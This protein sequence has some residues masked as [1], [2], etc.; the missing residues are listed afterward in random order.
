MVAASCGDDR[1]EPRHSATALADGVEVAVDDPDRLIDSA[2]VFL[3]DE[4]PSYLSLHP[5][6]DETGIA[7]LQPGEGGFD[8]VVVV[9][10]TGPY[11]GLLPEVSVNGDGSRMQIDVRS[12]SSTDCDAMQYDEAVGFQVVAGHENDRVRANHS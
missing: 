9:Y 4:L 8:V 5:E 11:C 12:R 2:T 1:G 7:V 10:R 3:P 6:L